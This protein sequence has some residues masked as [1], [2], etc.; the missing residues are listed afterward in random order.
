MVDFT[1]VDL[2]NTNANGTSI[3][4]LKKGK[5]I[6]EQIPDLKKMFSDVR[7][8]RLKKATWV[9]GQVMIWPKVSEA[10]KRQD[11]V[12]SSNYYPDLQFKALLDFVDVAD[13]SMV[14][15]LY[16]SIAKV[17]EKLAKNDYAIGYL[18]ED[19]TL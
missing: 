8:I 17:Y 10:Q 3:P 6:N 12:F 2:Q 16:H 11:A 5:K 9:D 14:S 15:L 1:L 18:T 4:L 19:A 7:V 13:P